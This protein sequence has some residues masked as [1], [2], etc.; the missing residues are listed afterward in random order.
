MVI[1]VLIQQS[2][3]WCYK[4]SQTNSTQY[5]RHAM[6]GKQMQAMQIQQSTKVTAPTAGSPPNAQITNS[7]HC[8]LLR[9]RSSTRISQVNIERPFTIHTIRVTR[10]KP[11]NLPAIQKHLLRALTRPELIHLVVHQWAATRERGRSC[12]RCLGA[13]M[14]GARRCRVCGRGRR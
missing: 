9:S 13:R 1:G 12:R 2:N 4:L 11:P 3:S 8:N 10:T 14:L 7:L 6:Q 5:K